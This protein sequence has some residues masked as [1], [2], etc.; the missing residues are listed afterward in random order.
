MCL[1]GTLYVCRRVAVGHKLNE[2]N[3]GNVTYDKDIQAKLLRG[4]CGHIIC[5]Y[6]D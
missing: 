4:I 1:F 5:I 3:S 2:V 6:T